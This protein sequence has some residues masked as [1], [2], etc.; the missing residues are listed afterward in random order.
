M[1]RFFPGDGRYL[2]VSVGEEHACAIRDDLT[3]ICVGANT[4]GRANLPA[5][6][7]LVMGVACGYAGS[8]W[9]LQSGSVERSEAR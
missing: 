2:Y 7:K 6:G 1:F 8:C 5:A 3:P 9:L 4:D